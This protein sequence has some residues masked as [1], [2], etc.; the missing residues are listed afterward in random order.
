M[1]ACLRVSRDFHVGEAF[2]KK[3]A[4]DSKEE[5]LSWRVIPLERRELSL[6]DVLPTGQAFRWHRTREE[7][8]EWSGV[9]K[10]R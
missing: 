5:E 9:I 10:G 8:E 2:S 7:P 3:M 1:R 6:A 4:D